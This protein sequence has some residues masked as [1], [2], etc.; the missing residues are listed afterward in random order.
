M[1]TPVTFRFS[2]TVVTIPAALFVV[3]TAGAMWVWRDQPTIAM[4]VSGILA[5][6]LIPMVVGASMRVGDVIMVGEKELSRSTWGRTQTVRWADVC[7]VELNATNVVVRSSPSTAII[8]DATHPAFPIVRECVLAFLRPLCLRDLKTVYHLE[9]Y[10]NVIGGI[11]TLVF[12]SMGVSSILLGRALL[13]PGVLAIVLAAVFALAWPSIPQRYTFQG[14]AFRIESWRNRRALIV[15]DVRSISLTKGRL[16]GRMAVRLVT[17]MGDVLDLQD[18]QEGEL[19]L[20]LS[21][22]EWSRRARVTERDPSADD[23]TSRRDD[24]VEERTLQSF[25]DRSDRAV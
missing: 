11:L 25:G 19:R 5:L 22:V 8:V 10:L 21:L 17:T 15:D 3:L 12:L 6:L 24:G 14:D 2:R 4:A 20:Y 9:P 7:G 13:M 1:A 23:P 18:L 16:P